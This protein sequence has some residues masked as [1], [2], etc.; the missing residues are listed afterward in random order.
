MRINFLLQK[1]LVSEDAAEEEQKKLEG[2]IES[3]ESIVR[4]FEIKMKNAQD[5]SKIQANILWTLIF[6]F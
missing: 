1:Y 3:L 4:L 2:K 5:Q 6:L